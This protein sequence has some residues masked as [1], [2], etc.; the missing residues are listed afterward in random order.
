LPERQCRGEG[1]FELRRK[2]VEGISPVC[3][4]TLTQQR[5][6]MLT[7]DESIKKALQNPTVRAE[8]ERLE[9]EEMPMLD[10]VLAAR[11]NGGRVQPLDKIISI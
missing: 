1:L 2:G 6:V 4:C 11:V 8:V 5:I 9:R 3:Y 7:H 10:A